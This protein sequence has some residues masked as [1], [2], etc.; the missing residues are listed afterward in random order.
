MTTAVTPFRTKSS[1]VATPISEHVSHSDEGPLFETLGF[2]EISHGSYQLFN[3]LPYLSLCTQYSI[4]ISLN[5]DLYGLA[6][7][8]DPK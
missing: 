3:F 6:E 8:L 5:R 7:F 1:L 4:L 2:F